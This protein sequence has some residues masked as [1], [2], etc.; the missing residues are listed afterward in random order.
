MNAGLELFG[1]IG[2]N[3]EPAVPGAAAQP[4]D[5][6]ADGE[7]DAERLDVERDDPGGL[8]GVEHDV[9]AVLVG[10]PDDPR[11]VLDLARLE[12]DVAHRH[13]E[14]PLVDRVVDGV[15][16]LADDD[17]E[18]GLGLVEV[19]HGRE[20]APLVDDAVALGG[21]AEARQDDRLRDRDVL[22]HHR[23]A[24]RRADDA[25][26]LVA[27][28]QRQ[29]PPPLPPRPDAALA[30]GAGVLRES[31]LCGG[32]HRPERVID[33]VRRVLE[34][35]EPGAVLEQRA[36]GRS[37]RSAQLSRFRRPSACWFHGTRCVVPAAAR[38]LR[39]S[40]YQS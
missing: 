4:L 10:A 3:V 29:V 15:V 20:V 17:L 31:L 9:S 18:V 27:D 19:A 36:H 11:H 16:A 33:Q 1:E 34:D 30:P 37:L 7:V 40:R 32:G 35:R 23:R 26:D 5:G 13:Q 8:I 28:G 25:A 24:G 39:L 6:A 21:R 14:R 38:L 2:S 12:E 22:V